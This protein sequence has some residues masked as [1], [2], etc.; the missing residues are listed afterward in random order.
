MSP[1]LSVH[2]LLLSA[3]A[4]IALGLLMLISVGQAGAT[5]EAEA[6]SLAAR[7]LKGVFIGGAAC[8]TLAFV[9]YRRLG[10]W[11]WL[12]MA[13]AVVLLTL[14]F[15][16]GVGVEELGARRWIDVPGLNFGLQPS[17][18]AKIA[19]VVFLAACYS[20]PDR[21][22]GCGWRGR[23]L[24]EVCIP[25]G[26]TAAPL[27]LIA[28]EKDLGATALLGAAVVTMLFVAGLR[29]LWLVAGG[30]AGLLGLVFL[31]YSSPE[32]TGRV[33]AYLRT[34]QGTATLADA[35]GENMQQ[36]MALQALNSGG[37][38]GSGLGN[39]VQ[40]LKKLPQQESDFIF[41]IIGEE[42][43]LQATLPVLMLFVLILL[44]G[45]SIAL[46]AGDRF[47]LL[48]GTGLVVLIACQ[49]FINMGVATA[50]LPNKG[51]A[52]PF[53]SLGGSNMLFC[54]SSI[55]IL[56][57]IHRHARREEEPAPSSVRLRR[58]TPCV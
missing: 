49:A 34:M 23:T 56:I 22:R 52:L 38:R 47:G 30:L 57:S 5:T 2:V 44:A 21:W 54:L 15:V 43:G 4:L 55:G 39:S 3:A 28:L 19:I 12:W 41:P 18:L 20:N 48:L 58:I 1:R 27:A 6:M 46:E 8:L 9:N 33:E 16:P 42:L 26:V 13:I 32:R 24:R 31:V 7:Q 53:I 17:E 36:E 29:A 40:K 37:L 50:V 35:S 25:L 14:C 10:R 11:R 51:M 45:M